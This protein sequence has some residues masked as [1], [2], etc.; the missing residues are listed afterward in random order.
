M[1]YGI[2]IFSSSKIVKK[3]IKEYG[4]NS[5]DYKIRK[6]FKTEK[7]ARC[8]E[9]KFLRKIKACS[10]DEWLNQNEGK[11]SLG[12]LGKKH[13]VETRQKMSKSQSG[14]NNPMYG[15]RHTKEAKQKIIEAGLG[16]THK[17]E[18]RK[19]LSEMKKGKPFSGYGGNSPKTIAK[20]SEKNRGKKRSPEAR[21][22]MRK[23][24]L[25]YLE[26]QDKY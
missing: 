8:W 26:R 21:E 2:N 23:A 3:L 14:K 17:E 5:F 12:M 13:S 9:T 19:K 15:K 10:N 22:N 24:R 16:R 6:I 20:R 7:E 4:I 25:A 1:I 11:A 18:T